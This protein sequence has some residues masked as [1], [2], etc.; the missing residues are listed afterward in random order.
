MKT[1]AYTTILAVHAMLLC[2]AVAAL[3]Q[4]EQKHGA[5]KPMQHGMSKTGM[6]SMMNQPHAALAMAYGQNIGTFARSL[7][8]QA[9]GS[10]PLDVGF[11]RAA[12]AEI[13]RSLDQMDDHHGEHVKTMSDAM[14]SDMA[15]MMKDMDMH[16]SMLKEAILALEKDVRA[17]QLD[18]KQVAGDSGNV[19]KHLDEMSKMHDARKG[20]Q[21]K[22]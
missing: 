21:M 13:K 1:R 16:R 12:V 4:A 11:A 8:R 3:A 18:A 17:D 5:Q 2:S 19:L 6:S 22:K 9:Q 20:K 14:R 10:S 15:A 7:R